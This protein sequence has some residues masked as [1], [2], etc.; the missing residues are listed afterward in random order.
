MMAGLQV[1]K[2]DLRRRMRDAL[3]QIPAD[4]IANQS[5]IAT[6]QLLSLQEYRDA[7]RI[8][9]YL[10]MP[11]GELS[12]TAI[13]QD[14]LANGKEV[15]VP[16]I[17][18]LE[19]SSQPK[20]S[21]MDMLLL[22]SM[23]EFRSLEPDKWGIPSLS[24]ASVLNKRNCFGGKGV[25]PQPEDSTQGPYGLDLIVMPGMAFDDG[26]RRLGH[27]KGYYDHFLTRYSKGPESTTTAPKLPLLVALALK[28]QMLDP[29]EKIPV[30][31]H[32]WLVDVLMVGDDRCLVRQR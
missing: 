31:D 11:A 9:V 23:D 12:T 29:T 10:S 13:V 5:R 14:A 18:N 4:S 28:E 1:A 16:Y 20:T 17:H 3:Q 6:N 22:E 30:A 19:L 21:V 7:K 26:F 8:G 15:F 2:R 24:Q 27:G 25:S 32:D